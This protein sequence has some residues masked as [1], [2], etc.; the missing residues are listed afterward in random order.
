MNTMEI[1]KK[2][3]KNSQSLNKIQTHEFVGKNNNKTPSGSPSG[4][5]KTVAAAP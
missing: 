3:L 2:R 1:Q 5:M 4:H